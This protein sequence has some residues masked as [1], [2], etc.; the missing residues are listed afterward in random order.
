MFAYNT[1]RTNQWKQNKSNSQFA[2][3]FRIHLCT[4]FALIL[5]SEMWQRVRHNHNSNR[6]YFEIFFFLQMTK[7]CSLLSSLIIDI[8]EWIYLTVE[9]I[10]C[11]LMKYKCNIPLSAFILRLYSLSHILLLHFITNKWTKCH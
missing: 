9:W 4:V 2:A 5:S 6:F 10:C 8:S 11:F 7:V 3:S 1:S